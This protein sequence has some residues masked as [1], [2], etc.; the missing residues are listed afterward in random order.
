M[1]DHNIGELKHLRV[2]Q[3]DFIEGKLNIGGTTGSTINF[4]DH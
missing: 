1:K 4:T 2:N 3:L